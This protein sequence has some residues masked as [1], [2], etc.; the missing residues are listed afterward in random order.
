MKYLKVICAWMWIY[1]RSS[2]HI[3]NILRY[4]ICQIQDNINHTY[5]Y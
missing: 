2:H 4:K 5:P 3:F 1:L